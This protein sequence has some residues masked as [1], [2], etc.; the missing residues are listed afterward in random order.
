LADLSAFGGW[1]L[2]DSG[3]VVADYDEGRKRFTHKKIQRSVD[4]V[5]RSEVGSASTHEHLLK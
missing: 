3:Q 1:K 4:N 5:Q 2:S